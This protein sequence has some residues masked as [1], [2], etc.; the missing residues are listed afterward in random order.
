M[1]LLHGEAI[2]A[3]EA[4]T[5][6]SWRVERETRVAV[7]MNIEKALAG[8]SAKMIEGSVVVAVVWAYYWIHCARQG[9]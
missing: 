5:I 6:V 9:R 2:V 4:S 3:V 8:A 1:R 7:G